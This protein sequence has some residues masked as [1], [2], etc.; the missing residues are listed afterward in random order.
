MS[1]REF[2]KD[3]IAEVAARHDLTVDELLCASIKRRFTHPRQEAMWEIR[4][5]T[6]LSFPQIAEK[7]GRKDHTTIIHGVR[8][9]ERRMAQS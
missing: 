4:Q 2:S 8:E 5:R 6:R 9:H 7:L 3:I 1:V